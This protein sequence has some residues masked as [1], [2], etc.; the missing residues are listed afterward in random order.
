MFIV[1]HP[2]FPVFSFAAAPPVVSCCAVSTWALTASVVCREPALHRSLRLPSQSAADFL[3]QTGLFSIS[4][5]EPEHGFLLF[6]HNVMGIVD[7]QTFVYSYT[8][9]ASAVHALQA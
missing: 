2:P 7:V 9:F 4:A 6:L 3:T 8:H 1:S 5:I